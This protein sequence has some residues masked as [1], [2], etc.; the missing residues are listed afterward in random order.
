[1]KETACY[2]IERRERQ[3]QRCRDA[4]DELGWH[5]AEGKSEVSIVSGCAN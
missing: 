4:R 3:G 1:M 5:E 2:S